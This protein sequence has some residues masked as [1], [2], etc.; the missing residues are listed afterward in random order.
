[1]PAHPARLL[2]LLKTIRLF[3]GL[4]EPQLTR[5]AQAAELIELQEGQNPELDEAQD[6]P[7]FAIAAGKVSLTPTESHTDEE[8]LLKKG[9]F[10]GA[11]VFF[12]GER[13]DYHIT[14]LTPVQLIAIPPERLR[15][16]IQNIPRLEANLKEQLRIYRLMRLRQFEWVNEDEWKETIKKITLDINN[17]IKWLETEQLPRAN[18]IGSLV[19]K[20]SLGWLKFENLEKLLQRS[21]RLENR[22]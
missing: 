3:Q 7:F 19:P 10:F 12:M 20:N 2:A 15:I 1:M 21:L 18:T 5:V 8:Y 14:A 4:D 16:L 11:D 9:D 13:E 17:Y 6:Y 22:C